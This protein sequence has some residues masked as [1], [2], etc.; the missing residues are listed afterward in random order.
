RVD[1]NIGT[2]RD[3]CVNWLVTAYNYINKPEIVIKAFDGCRVPNREHLRLSFA[4]LTSE[5]TCQLLRDIQNND[6]ELWAAIN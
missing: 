2:L 3:R 5:E 4:T 1:F 6:P